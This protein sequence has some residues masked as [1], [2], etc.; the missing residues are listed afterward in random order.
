[1]HLGA[2]VVG[3]VTAI[4]VTDFKAEKT[5]DASSKLTTPVYA[6]LRHHPFA[7]FQIEKVGKRFLKIR[8]LCFNHPPVQSGLKQRV[9]LSKYSSSVLARGNSMVGKR[10]ILPAPPYSLS[11]FAN[12]RTNADRENASHFDFKPTPEFESALDEYSS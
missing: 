3:L 9:I 6:A 2:N 7:T 11:R 5:L 1:M 10:R 8:P 12:N 4:D